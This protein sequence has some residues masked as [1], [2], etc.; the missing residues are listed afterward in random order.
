MNSNRRQ[1]KRL[2][3]DKSVR[4]LVQLFPVM[5][6]I[7]ETME[8]QLINISEGGISLRLIYPEKY[9]SLARG[10]KVRLHL[11]L[12]GHPLSE[13]RG[14]ITHALKAGETEPMLGIRFQKPPAALMKEIRH[15]ATDSDRCD[16]RTRDQAPWCD[17]SCTFHNLCRKPIRI[18]QDVENADLLMEIALQRVE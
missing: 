18:T 15:M 16:R 12:P 8:A 3:I 7:G 6:F 14:E 9:P 5:P 11:R 4:V 13:C 10:S 2:K 17:I 1:F